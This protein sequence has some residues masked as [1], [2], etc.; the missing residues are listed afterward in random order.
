MTISLT[1]AANNARQDGLIAH[2][3]AGA[4]L[5]I[6]NGTPPANI[7]AALSG[8]TQ[9]AEL[10]CGTPFA[11]AAAGNGVITANPITQDSAADAT[12]TASFYRIY[13][14]DGTTPVLQGTVTATGGGGDLEL[15]TVNIVVG[16]PV[17]VTSWTLTD[18]N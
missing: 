14:A 9:L 7:D 2:I 1:N 12:G 11:P 3:G 16:G 15:N 5:R 13:K 10:T 8:N 17:A 6:Y 4:K 18:G